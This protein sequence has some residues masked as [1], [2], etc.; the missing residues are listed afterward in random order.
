MGWLII[1]SL[2]LGIVAWILPLLNLSRAQANVKRWIT[3]SFLSFICCGM[4]ILFQL[5][6][7]NLFVEIEDFTALMDI[8]GTSVLA[9]SVLFLVTIVLNM[10]A[11]V[12]FTK[13][14]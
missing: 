13:M 9:A 3:Y 10:F 4:A 2:V 1:G 12:K 7:Q 6:V 14:I 8:T 11:W 5:I